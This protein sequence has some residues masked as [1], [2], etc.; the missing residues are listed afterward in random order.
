MSR[1]GFWR[2]LYDPDVGNS[3]ITVW[4]TLSYETKLINRMYARWYWPSNLDNWSISIMSAVQ[5]RAC[6]TFRFVSLHNTTLNGLLNLLVL[7][8][9]WDISLVSRYY[10]TS[11]SITLIVQSWTVVTSL[12]YCDFLSRSTVVLCLLV[13]TNKSSPKKTDVSW[14]PSLILTDSGNFAKLHY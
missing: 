8:C 7:L 4:N 2:D 1:L 9:I 12:A 14:C 6:L 10:F 3:R 13:S 5:G 11:Y